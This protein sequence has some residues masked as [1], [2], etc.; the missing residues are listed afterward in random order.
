MGI[1][2]CRTVTDRNSKHG[3]RWRSR[4]TPRP[5]GLVFTLLFSPA[6]LAHENQEYDCRPDIKYECTADQCEKITSDFQ[7]AESFAYS[8]QT[9]EIS[10]CLWTNCYADKA[11]VFRDPTARTLTVI[12]RLIPTAHPGNEPIIVS[13]TIDNSKTDDTHNFT[14][15]WGYRSEGLTL[16]MGKCVTQ[17]SRQR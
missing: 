7:H 11:T 16:D 14:A 13:L 4:V 15:I 8:A 5:F 6:G 1:R 9:G 10:A 2:D 12:G 17:E 3:S